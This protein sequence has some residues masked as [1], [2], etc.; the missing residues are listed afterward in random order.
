MNVEKARMRVLLVED[1]KAIRD[2]VCA[3]LVHEDFE[4]TTTADGR[5]ALDTFD[6]EPFDL[7]ILDL[8][9]PLIQGEDVCRII[10][11]SSDVPIIILTAK[12]DTEDRIVGLEL[13]ADD[14]LVKPFALRELVARIRAIIRRA[15]SMPERP[16]AVLDFGDLVINDTLHT[17]YVKGEELELTA[18]EFKLLTMLAENPGHVF[19][20]G[21]LVDKILGS[22]FERDERTIDSHMKNL[23]SKLKDSPRNPTWLQTVHGVGYRFLRPARTSDNRV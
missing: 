13:G 19:P 12:D 4:I 5:D 1:D 22:S 20:R 10:R 17:V 9:L 16:N 3:Y 8:V 2:A 15:Q 23:R 7:V 11:Q 18:S 14:Y 6:R 21:E